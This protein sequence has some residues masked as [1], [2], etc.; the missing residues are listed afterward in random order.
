MNCERHKHCPTFKAKL[1][2][3]FFFFTPSLSLFPSTLPPPPFFIIIIIVMIN[4]QF[5]N[6]KLRPCFRLPLPQLFKYKRRGFNSRVEAVAPF[7]FF[8][9]VLSSSV[10]LS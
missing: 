4:P 6:V 2:S 1:Y 10:V 9:R 8:L 5:N 7:F 3:V